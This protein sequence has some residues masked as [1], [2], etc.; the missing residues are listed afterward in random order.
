MAQQWPPPLATTANAVSSSSNTRPE[1]DAAN[2]NQPSPPPQ[3][4]RSYFGSAE[5]SSSTTGT[6][7]AGI[8]DT[9]T[10]QS[11]TQPTTTLDDSKANA[12]APRVPHSH[13]SSFEAD[14]ERS[15]TGGP[16]S[17]PSTA[18]NS[19]RESATAQRRHHRPSDSDTS[20]DYHPGQPFR[21]ATGVG[22]GAGGGGGQ[23]P[24][25]PSRPSRRRNHRHPNADVVAAY[26]GEDNRPTSDKE[27]LGWY[28]YA[29]ASETY[30]ICGMFF[31]I[32]Q[33]ASHI[34]QQLSSNPLLQLSLPSFPSSSRVSP[35]K[36]ASFYPTAQRPA[37]RA[38]R[39]PN[40][41]MPQQ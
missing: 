2:D 9:L 34:A 1:P 7:G 41:R 24:Q 33:I 29:F 23:Q 12:P 17:F 19:I 13:S 16:R 22:G 39:N 10:S 14:D 26:A 5:P 35:A 27:I 31:P 21:M 37:H 8:N 20:S 3:P 38:T 6:G 11:T 36:M 40:H 32:P 4:Q 18:T 15:A 30:V 28:M 25:R